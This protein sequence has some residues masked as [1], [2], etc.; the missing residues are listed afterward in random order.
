MTEAAASTPV[1]QAPQPF[2]RQIELARYRVGAT[3]R[4]LV[5]SG[6]AGSIRITD[7]PA[8]GLGRRYLVDSKLES[9][10]EY[11]PW[12]AD[13]LDQARRLG[14]CPMARTAIRRMLGEGARQREAIS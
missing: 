14:A 6:P 11:E 10:A 13:Y 2:Q 8:S 5:A 7:R 1:P 3:E 4:V 12:L 9:L